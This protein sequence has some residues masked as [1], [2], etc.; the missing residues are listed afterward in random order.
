MRVPAEMMSSTAMYFERND[1]F[2]VDAFQRHEFDY[3][4]GVGKVP[5]ANFLRAVAGKKILE[6][7]AATYP[8]PLKKHD[9]PI[10]VYYNHDAARMV[11]GA[12]ASE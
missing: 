4:E 9:V 3:L 8:S 2:V 10:W 1:A 6:K 12:G 5:E 11:M 7:L